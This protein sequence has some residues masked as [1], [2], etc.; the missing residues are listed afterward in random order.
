MA[1]RLA[2]A[3]TG[4]A[5]EHRARERV[6]GAFVLVV[7][8]LGCTILWIGIPLGGLW[9]LGKATDDFVTHFVVGLLGVP[10]LMVLYA[11]VLFWL[12]DLYLRVSGVAR[13][14]AEDEQESG[15]RRRVGGPLEPM[16]AISFVVELTAFLIWFFFIAENPPPI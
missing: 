5:R 2:L 7:M 10:V 3:A 12:N 8:A 13:R 4:P 15:W 6:A 9:A 16:L 1:A 11:P 14:I